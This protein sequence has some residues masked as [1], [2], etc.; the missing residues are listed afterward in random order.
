MADD[1]R[2][3]EPWQDRLVGQAKT[4]FDRSGTTDATTGKTAEP[5][6]GWTPADYKS[7]NDLI[8]R[9]PAPTQALTPAPE[10][11]RAQKADSIETLKALRTEIA[12]DLKRQG[13]AM[14]NEK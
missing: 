3:R 7:I 12:A 13:L 1:K 14:E 11:V 9:G 4:A 10:K 5:V 6:I 8:H 2:P